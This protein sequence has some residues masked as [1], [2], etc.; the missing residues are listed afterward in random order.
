MQPNNQAPRW[1]NIFILCTGRCGST[2][3]IKAS[4]H[5]TNYS[6]GHETRTARVGAERF[7]Y[8][9]FHIEADNRL[10]W[11][12]GRLDRH[13]GSTPF[14]VHLKRDRDLVAQSFVKRADRGIMAGYRN[15]ILMPRGKQVRPE[16]DI[17]FALDYIDTVD[18]NIAMFLQDKPNKM[19]FQLEN[20]DQD[21]AD[22]W[23]RIGAE[24]DFQT[25]LSEFGVPYNAS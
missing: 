3:I 10:S 22:F 2:T 6:S 20:S 13:F 5:C 16:Q 19:M 23:E 21:F 18:T 17:D 1:A 4:S 11:L 15:A 9:A 25:A 12:L 24:G 14:Y 8:P 7:A